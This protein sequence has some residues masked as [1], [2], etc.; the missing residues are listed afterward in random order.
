MVSNVI[1]LKKGS[2]YLVDKKKEGSAL[3]FDSFM[4]RMNKYSR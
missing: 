4:K 3:N 1:F 2:L